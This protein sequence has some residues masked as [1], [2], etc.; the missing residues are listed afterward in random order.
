MR[1]L[2][3][4]GT[5]PRVPKRFRNHKRYLLR[6]DGEALLFDQKLHAEWQPSNPSHS[7]AQ[8]RRVAPVHCTGPLSLSSQ[9][10]KKFSVLLELMLCKTAS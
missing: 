9:K 7:P 6:R 2:V 3:V 10:L 8:Q 1:E 4:L 5:D